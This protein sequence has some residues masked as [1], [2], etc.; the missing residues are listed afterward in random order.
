[1]ATVAKLGDALDG[2]RELLASGAS[3]TFAGQT[4]ASIA[5]WRKSAL[6]SDLHRAI[7]SRLPMLAAVGVALMVLLPHRF[8]PTV[9]QHT[10]VLAVVSAFCVGMV[11]NVHELSNLKTR[12][13][14]L[15]ALFGPTP[16]PIV[17]AET[18]PRITHI[19]WRDVTVVY[20]DRVVLSN[21]TFDVSEGETVAV[22]GPNGAGKTTLLEVALGLR[23]LTKGQF[24]VGDRDL[25]QVL[26][27]LR[28]RVH[29]VPQRPYLLPERSVRAAML[30]PPRDVDDEGMRRALE[31][32]GLWERLE[33]FSGDPLA[34]PTDR[35][36]AGERQRLA[37]AR[38]LCEE[39]DVY[40][41]DEPDANLD[42]EGVE[43]VVRLLGSLA[44][45]GKLVIVAAHTR[46]LI[47]AADRVVRLDGG[48]AISI[49]GRGR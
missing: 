28:S 14:P 1:L 10:A 38:I 4:R 7:V 45:T 32:V 39:R 43:W 2:R 37:L 3:G 30:F 40:L 31:R 42:A 6:M 15:M 11:R 41:L 17:P 27:S 9:I 35:L 46:E 26:A 5:R 16:I 21:V 33:T 47:A 44:S 34:A 18:T 36:S 29:Y 24:L 49:A 20:G 25:R 22:E 23:K 13:A 48:R 12:L 19:A 8:E